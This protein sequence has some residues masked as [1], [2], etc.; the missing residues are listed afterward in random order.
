M[1]NVSRTDIAHTPRS[2]PLISNYNGRNLS[3]LLSLYFS[4]WGHPPDMPT[5]IGVNVQTANSAAQ[6]QQQLTTLSVAVA[7]AIVAT[8]RKGVAIFSMLT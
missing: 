5:E 2:T 1:S 8:W 4:P 3:L 7:V 6:K